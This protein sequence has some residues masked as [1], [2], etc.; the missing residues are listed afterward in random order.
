MSPVLLPSLALALASGQAPAP[1]PIP[2]APGRPQVP[3]PTTTPAPAATMGDLWLV[4]YTVLPDKT[5]DFEAVA[6]QVRE[7]LGKSADPV[8]QAQARD[9]RIHRSNLPNAEGRHLYFLQ[10]PALTGDGDRSGF[11]ALIDAVLPE[12]ATALKARLTATLDP[13][14]PSGNTYLISLR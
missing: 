5:T 13:T 3:A 8:R 1:Q 7:A 14:N 4:I 10:I 12:Q 6:R 2:A 9:L 11:D